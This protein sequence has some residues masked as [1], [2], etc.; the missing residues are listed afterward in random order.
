MARRPRFAPP[1]Y[2]LHLTQRGNY[3]QEIFRHDQDRRRYLE[4]LAHHAAERQV[5][6][7]GYCLMPNHVH[8]IALGKYPH[9]ISHFM[10]CLNG[11][12]AQR[13][14]S[15]TETTGRFW[16]GR[17]HSTVLD[18][19]H[20]RAALRYVERNPVRAALTLDATR[21]PWS[22][23]AAHS[24]LVP[25]PAFL[26]QDEFALRY[27]AHQWRLFIAEPQ[28][29]AEVNAIRQATRLGF[30]LGSPDFFD[31]LEAEFDVRL[32]RRRPA[33]LALSAAR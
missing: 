12:H 22:S 10:R 31:R 14:H 11:H 26:N 18:E 20:L 2:W 23:A 9:A 24:G 28:P 1:G 30:P 29:L 17:Y 27:T 25:A 13:L 3:R 15:L 4:L 16:Q 21:Y 7:L 32:P 6:I 5:Q 33:E 8:L 19:S